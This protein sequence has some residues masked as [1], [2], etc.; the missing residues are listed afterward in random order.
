MLES[1]SLLTFATTTLSQDYICAF[2]IIF[3][4]GYDVFPVNALF[5][6]VK[7][8]GSFFSFNNLFAI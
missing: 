3:H 1:S 2:V 7:F 6:L 4:A 8:Y 5:W